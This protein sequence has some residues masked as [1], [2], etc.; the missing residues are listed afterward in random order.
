[1]HSTVSSRHRLKY[2]RAPMAVCGTATAAH[3]ND[4]ANSFDQNQK[5][6]KH[7]QKRIYFCVRN[8]IWRTPLTT[9]T[10]TFFPLSKIGKKKIKKEKEIRV[11]CEWMTS[12][13][14]CKNLKAK[15]VIYPPYKKKNGGRVI[16]WKIW[17]YHKNSWNSYSW[18]QQ[19]RRII[20]PSDAKETDHLFTKKKRNR[21]PTSL[22]QVF[23]TFPLSNF[24]IHLPLF[25]SS[26][27]LSNSSL[28]WEIYS[29]HQK[30]CS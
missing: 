17:S 1:M 20:I 6:L 15:Y 22:P 5:R 8:T 25:K 24:L 2:F 27:Y 30:N 11:P 4:P 12:R 9:E 13:Y 10:C 7:D 16:L 26:V 29:S 18:L 14:L 19:F 3:G 21:P 23:L 28:D